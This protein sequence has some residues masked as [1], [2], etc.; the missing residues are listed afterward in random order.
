MLYLPLLQPEIENFFNIK[1]EEFWFATLDADGKEVACKQYLFA[2]NVRQHPV[3]LLYDIHATSAV[4]QLTL[5]TDT[6]PSRVLQEPIQDLFFSQLKMSDFMKHGSI[7]RTMGLAKND[8]TSLYQSIINDDVSAYW[9]IR[10]M[11]EGGTKAIPVKLYDVFSLTSE[12]GSYA[13]GA[14]FLGRCILA[15]LDKLTMEVINWK[16]DIRLHGVSVADIPILWFLKL[17]QA[18]RE[19]KLCGYFL[20]LPFII[21]PIRN[22]SL[23]LTSAS[24]LLISDSML[25]F[26]SRSLTWLSL[27]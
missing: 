24:T 27:A 3:G 15:D 9:N 11:L 17:T 8:Q 4:W 22:Y 5:Q 26:S 1:L 20:A 12:A 13:V 16:G 6:M 25:R 21:I 23:Y 19:R 7:K 2:S 10:K 14:G 18:L